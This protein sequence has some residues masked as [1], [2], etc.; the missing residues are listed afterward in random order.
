MKGDT[1]LY[2]RAAGDTIQINRNVPP[3]VGQSGKVLSNNGVNYTWVVNSASV[4][5]GGITGTLSDQTD[6][7]SALDSKLSVNGNGSSLTGITKSQI[8]LANADNTSDADKPVSTATQAALNLKANTSSLPTRV[9]LSNDVVNNNAV[10]N[11]IA[12]VTGLSFPVIANNTYK[13]RFVIQYRSAATTTGSRWTINGPANTWV[14]YTSQYT[15]TA[16][17]ITNNA[18]VSAYNSPSGAS[19]S[20]LASGNRCIIEG[21]IR[22][23]ADGT[24]IAR[25]ASEIASSAITALGSNRSYVEYQIIN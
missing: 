24:V 6:L 23:S 19:A 16:T 8:G 22:P 1:L 14:S 5:W 4:S 20:S 3:M 15:L 9:W 18:G 21:E 12:D 10:A 17:S 2:V 7:Q 13:F 25:F 11:T